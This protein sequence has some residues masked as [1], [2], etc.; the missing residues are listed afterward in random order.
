MDKIIIRGARQHNLKNLNID[1]PKNQIIIITGISGSGKSTLAFDTLYAEGQR[2]Y[3]ESLSAYAR[4]FL[5]QM[6]RP[7]VDSI[8]GLS[9]AIAIEQKTATR[10]PRS[11]VG[12]ITE[13]Y[14]YLGLLF[15]R[16]GDP[17]CPKCGQ[18]IKTKTIQQI[19]DE[20]LNLPEGAK[21]IIMAPLAQHEKGDHVKLLKQLRKKGFAR[22]RID[23]D[24]KELDQDITVDKNI[25]H[26]ID[27]VI[28]RLIVKKSIR[29]RL[30]D[31]LELA[32]G[33]SSGVVAVAV[34]DGDELVFSER[35]ACA[36][37][38]V[39]LPDF[40]PAS[41]SFNS[42][43]G[44]CSVC[45]GLGHM[46]RLDPELLIPNP[47]LSVN[48]GAIAPWGDRQRRGYLHQMLE[49][50]FRHYDMDLDTPFLNLPEK[51]RDVLLYGSKDE[52]IPFQYE[53]GK[54]RFSC[55]KRLE[56]VIPSLE[57]RYRETGS[58]RVRK[59]IEQYMNLNI[60]PE[61]NGARLKSE[62]RSVRIQ[63]HSIDQ[64]A[65]LTISSA[66]AFFSSLKL[67]PLKQAIAE[68]IMREVAHRLSFL[69]DV[70]V[71]YL[72]LDRA[73]ASLS[74]GEAQ[75]VRLATQ[76]GSRLTGVLYVL[77]EPSIGLHQRDTERLLGTL[78][79]IRDLGNTVLVVEHDPETILNADYVID[80]G[81]GAGIEGGEIIFSGTP[82]KLL[83]HAKSITG[84][85]LSGKKGIRI[86]QNRRTVQAGVMTLKE[87]CTNN[88]KKIDISFPLGRLIC[89]TGVS[90][91][92]KSSLALE[93]LYPELV[94]SLSRSKTGSGRY[95]SLIGAENVNR[96]INIDQSPIGRTPRSNAATYTGIFDNIRELIAQTP[97]ARAR[98]YKPGRFSF[99][100]KGG[101]CEACQGEGVMR[102]DM[103][104]LPDIQV[105][106]DVCHGKRY[107]RETLE[108]EYKGKTIEGLL[109]LKV[110]E[111]LSFFRNISK[112]RRPLQTLVDVG[113]GYICLG[114]S[115]TTLSGGEA[116]RLKLTRELTRR[117]IGHTVYILDEPTTG[118]HMADIERLLDVLNRLIDAGNTVIVIEHN[119]EVIRSSDYIIDLGPEG[120]DQGGHIVGCGTPEEIARIESS[121]TGMFL[122]KILASPK[123]KV[124]HK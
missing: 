111:A 62:V 5:E 105:T 124:N 116:Q 38:G 32:M 98:G 106:C 48:N 53:Q 86:P 108:I 96:V 7:E 67:S 113:L 56:G 122:S 44:A 11:T 115:A 99:N 75:R 57:R 16:A 110:S 66:R 95:L 109:N 68:P 30:S 85:Y 22:V 41:F 69:D 72:S 34:L 54:I 55:S 107:N 78:K 114:Q 120:G 80:M 43:Q 104:F 20:L 27:V 88:L 14:D 49:A 25:P 23:G 46:R 58:H 103:Q 77:D 18:Q 33:E 15:A 3:V 9:P 91:S 24:I 51:F 101:R 36:R 17:H 118:L 90:G 89:V 39:S 4:Q 73:S 74:G 59:E 64:I 82:K 28:D 47:S 100:V 42:P 35:N 63:G 6:D 60:C 121:Y 79:E 65:S 84:A 97:E 40:G 123:I 93:T 29:N 50:V 92:G 8:E 76:I 112:I 1:I 19:T 94:R 45:D 87:V 31:S 2:R 26:T 10:N 61:C 12:T 13:V 52:D 83:S 21:I 37:C 102:I 70:G 119:M 117:G 71:G 81:P